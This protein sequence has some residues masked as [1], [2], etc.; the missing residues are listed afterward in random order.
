MSES[1]SSTVSDALRLDLAN[2]DG[3][4]P[5]GA[6]AAGRNS[7]KVSTPLLTLLEGLAIVIASTASGVGYHEFV[8]GTPGSVSTFLGVGMLAG[9]LY[10]TSMGA[11]DRSK[12]MRHADSFE[13]FRDAVVVWTC[14]VL[15]VTF[16]AFSLKFGAHLS[17]G[18]MLTFF[19]T[20]YVGLI[21]VRAQT[22]RVTK[23]NALSRYVRSNQL[24]LVGARQSAAIEELADQVALSEF[25]KSKI[26]LLD[27]NCDDAEW[28]TEF[29]RA[30]DEIFQLARVS[31]PG[32]ICVSAAGFSRSRLNQLLAGLTVVPRAV[33][34]VP[35]AATQY[36]L[37]LPLRAIGRLHS[38]ELQRAPLNLRQ[39]ALKRTMD[40]LI[41]IPAVVFVSPLLIGIAIMIRL[42]SNG[43]ALFRQSRLGLNGRPFNILK[44]RT[45]SVAE[46][47]D[48]VQQVT[49]SDSRVTNI[50]R[51]LR[52]SSLDELPQLLNVIQG[53]MSL[54]G[55]RPH[56]IAHDMHYARLIP[57]YEIRQHVL[58]GIT[59]WAQV[60][61]LRGETAEI[62][63]MVQR[64]E[65]DI[66]YAVN[67]SLLLD[68]KILVKTIG[69]V[70][71]SRNAF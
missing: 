17:R 52:K 13:A 71:R 50:G 56:A 5:G 12:Q 6:S 35:D 3:R 65:H 47:G 46:N 19:A 49:R 45:M 32:D 68:L 14:V 30:L 70:L 34:L 55:P 21:A 44:F 31:G 7:I 4:A 36:L 20:A 54:V 11:I 61:G 64:V 59:G 63:L 2:R 38:V 40:L 60:H 10:C 58:P 39:R 53:E 57:N 42:D 1:V 22:A 15:F 27:A 28:E 24:I 25:R 41:A 66:W 16:L 51:W 67:A 26:L 69:V 43:P 33:Q 48:H 29:S 9:G 18:T 23:W 8:L 37:R 62:R